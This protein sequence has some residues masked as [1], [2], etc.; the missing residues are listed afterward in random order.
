MILIDKRYLQDERTKNDSI[1]R[2]EI[3]AAILINKYVYNVDKLYVGT[4]PNKKFPD[5]HN[6]ATIGF[7]VVR[8]EAQVDFL[9][10]DIVKE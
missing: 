9:H 2:S 10:T 6:N 8:C 7:E 1:V 4:D 5:I 3:L